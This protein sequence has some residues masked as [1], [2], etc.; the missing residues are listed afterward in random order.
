VLVFAMAASV[1]RL[2][3]SDPDWQPASRTSKRTAADTMA[4]RL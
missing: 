1:G 3:S 2:F 4:E